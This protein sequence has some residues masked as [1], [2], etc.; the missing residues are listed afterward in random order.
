MKIMKIKFNYI[1]SAIFLFALT[2][3]NEDEV[4]KDWTDANP[5]PTVQVP[6]G[7]AGS[8]DLSN[9]VAIGNSLTAGFMDGA[10]YDDGQ[11][12]S[13]ANILAT[14]MSYAGGGT[15]NQPNIDSEY[16]YNSAFSDLEGGNIAGRS[17]LD[18]SIP[19][20][21]A[22]FNGDL[23]TAYTGTKSELNNFG[24]PGMKLGD[25]ETAGY[26]FP[27]VG[28]PYFTRFAADPNTSSVLG[29]AL[30]TN[31]TF[32]SLWLGANDYLGYALS[33]GQLPEPLST[34]SQVDF[35]TDLS[36]AL[37]QLVG[38]GAEGV[39][40][41]LPPVVTL[42]FFQAVAWNAIALDEATATQLNTGLAGAN[43]AIQ[44]AADNMFIGQA[45]ADAR[46]MSYAAGSN[47]ILV[48]DEE[49]TDLGPFFDAIATGADRAALVP[50]EQSRPLVDGELV[51]L[52][53][54]AIL[55]TEADGNDDVA[56]TPIGVAIPLGFSFTAAANGDQYFLNSEEI[57]AIV[58]ARATYNQTI[59]GVI[60]GFQ[61]SGADI[62][63]VSVQPTFVDMLG[64]DAASAGALALPTA[65][66]DGVS[67]LEIEGF[68]LLPDFSPNGLLSTDAVHPNPRGHAVIANLIIDAINARWG[69][70]IPSAEVVSRRAVYFSAD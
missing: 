38:T 1:F 55:G 37:T 53:A 15:F 60:D 42:P 40:L 14:Q 58:T 63:L 43:G 17:Y 12:Q 5:A 67:G 68:N 25:L 44:A 45:D 33:G 47:P 57:T 39:V 65:S 3:C 30:A 2:A 9:Y 10:L 32:F 66:A 13:Y 29:D 21:N 64:L 34:Y 27:D 11:S 28:N 24:V 56:D 18:L 52:T 54:G 16:G 48:H 41:D 22:G 31:P 36:S 6:S 35:Q 46:K 70:S 7:D 50:Y 4:L 8:L 19:G 23:I 26:G 59:A 69:A 61:T 62:G 20:P 51:L 49:L